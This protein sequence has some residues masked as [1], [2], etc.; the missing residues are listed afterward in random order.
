MVTR[1]A[2]RMPLRIR[3]L[4]RRSW[5]WRSFLRRHGIH[6]AEAIVLAGAVVALALML[7]RGAVLP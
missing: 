6:P 4:N 5:W 2:E 7:L 1:A 3:K